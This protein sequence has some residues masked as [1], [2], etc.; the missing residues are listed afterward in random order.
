M[1][2]IHKKLQ[3]PVIESTGYQHKNAVMLCGRYINTS[4]IAR[5][6]GMTQPHVSMIINGVR[7]VKLGYYIRIANAIGV[8]LQELVDGIEERK[9][10]LREQ[11]ELIIKSYETRI[12]REDEEDR[13][14]RRRGKVAIPRLPGLRVAK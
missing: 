7:E 12:A 3:G 8:T 1:R 11:A 14:R 5:S 9:A 4:A 10:L 6:Q 2:R 13:I